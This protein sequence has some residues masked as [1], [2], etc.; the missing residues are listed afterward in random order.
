MP[1]LT[2]TE[3]ETN[4]LA[5]TQ[6]ALNGDMSLLIPSGR[7]FYDP[8]AVTV[9]ESFQ[10]VGYVTKRGTLSETCAASN[11][12]ITLGSSH[13]A[14]QFRAGDNC[15][16]VGNLY[17]G[18]L[19]GANTGDAVTV[20]GVSPSNQTVTVSAATRAAA[21]FAVGSSLVLL[22]SNRA[23][24][25]GGTVNTASAGAE[26]DGWAAGNLL[27]SMEANCQ[28]GTLALTAVGTTTS[29]DFPPG[30][31]TAIMANSLVGGTVTMT[32]AAAPALQGCTG[33]VVSV[34]PGP[35]VTCD[36][37][38]LK[39][40]DGEPVAAW[41]SAPQIA[42]E[43]TLVLDLT[44][45]K[46]GSLQEA[47][48]DM[49]TLVSAALTMHRKL[50]PTGQDPEIP[51]VNELDLWLNKKGTLL[52]MSA[53]YTAGALTVTVEMDEAVGD[54]PIPLA[55]N[56]RIWNYQAGVGNT[57]WQAPSGALS[58][59]GVYVSYTRARRSN[60]LTCPVAPDAAVNFPVGSQ[61]ELDPAING[62][63]TNQGFSS[64]LPGKYLSGVL[65]QLVSAYVAYEPL[66]S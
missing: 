35:Q 26:V 53:P 62:F 40:T 3:V 58:N 41:P 32:T 44:N 30:A 31:F 34:T 66:G 52:T 50:D 28:P 36:L 2:G 20:V 51:L 56:I 24:V 14:A 7:T 65:W 4:L 48:P 64:N 63:A 11:T 22:A 54:L 23:T 17:A 19:A 12:T 57:A 61:V 59:G 47:G 49:T 5:L 46:L 45:G 42:D 8:S 9:P 27:A 18:A 15:F 60:V 25:P 39:D 43:A 29:V 6:G 13:E 33:K 37:V 10:Y 38:D 16:L 21:E 55:G 1:T